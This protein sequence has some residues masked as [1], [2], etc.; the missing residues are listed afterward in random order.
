MI[1]GG[2]I[3]ALGAAGAVG[4]LTLGRRRGAAP[5]QAS[6]AGAPHT[7]AAGGALLFDADSLL[8]LQ[9]LLSQYR[10]S[11]TEALAVRDALA[12][13]FRGKD[14]KLHIAARLSSVHGADDQILSLTARA[15]DGSGV[16]LDR[17]SGRLV[18][19]PLAPG[20]QARLCATATGEMNA[21]SFASSFD[22]V[23]HDEG[24]VAQFAAA[25][26][27]DI[28]F[29]H[30]LSPGCQFRGVYQQSVDADGNQVGDRRLVFAFLDVKA[31]HDTDEFE[32]GQ[33]ARDV[34]ARTI[35]LYLFDTG[36]GQASW[37]DENGASIV[38]GLMRTPVDGA[39]VTSKFG[40]R[41]HPIYEVVKFHEGVDFGCPVGTPVY[42]AGDGEVVIA[43]VVQG[44]GNYLRIKHTDHLWTA[45]GH[46]SGYAPTTVVGAKV[47]QGQVVAFTGNTGNST[48]PH[49]H[50][51]IR[52]DGVAVDPL[53]FHTDRTSALQGAQLAA[54]RQARDRI[55]AVQTDCS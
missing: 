21:T 1:A 49:L 29:T 41:M 6:P 45:Y 20:L 43:S 17:V 39:R 4:V 24:L 52:V 33:T 16:R 46:L 3:V 54:F 48:G 44:Y 14:G 12:S 32:G 26:A 8:H 2:G 28:N 13:G 25:M 40:L 31:I 18:S 10:I 30:D 37:F 53:T 34:A 7:A 23:M 36:D 42:A 15:L 22:R 38:R 5:P 50:F 19:T 35:K 11:D 27:Y 9:I 51:E 55:D 47:K